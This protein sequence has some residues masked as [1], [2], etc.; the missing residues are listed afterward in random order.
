MKAF[1]PI[2]FCMLFWAVP[3]AMAGS[4][5]AESA[6]H[7]NNDCC[8]TTSSE[9]CNI[10]KRGWCGKRKGDGYG[11]RRPVSSVSDAFEQLTKYFSGQEMVVSDVT[12]KQ[13]RFEA[14]LL[15]SSGKVV[16]RVMIDKRSGRVRSI[17]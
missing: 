3:S 17:Y 2:L 14:D 5:D 13:W 15:D 8:K 4:A 6:R 12:E 9:Q 7:R 11:A 1:L 10:V 16:D